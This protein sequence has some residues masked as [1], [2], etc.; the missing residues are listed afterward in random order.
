MSSPLLLCHPRFTC[1]PCCFYII[2]VTQ[3]SSMFALCHPCYSY[4]IPVLLVIPVKLCNLCFPFTFHNCFHICNQCYLY[5]IH[6]TFVIHINFCHLFYSNAIHVD[7]YLCYPCH[8]Y[9]IIVI[10]RY[11]CL[12][13][14]DPIII[15]VNLVNL[16]WTLLPLCQPIYPQVLSLPVFQ[17]CYSYDN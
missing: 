10:L 17:H 5:V 16:I 8:S 14:D 3:M 7:M 2:P 12:P 15:H 9:V 6:V 1:H 4:F 11:P 13:Y